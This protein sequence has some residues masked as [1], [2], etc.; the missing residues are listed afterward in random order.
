MILPEQ[1]AVLYRYFRCRY[2]YNDKNERQIIIT[3]RETHIY[4]R[5]YDSNKKAEQ[6]DVFGSLGN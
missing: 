2:F 5:V 6:I 1:C 3:K 4:A